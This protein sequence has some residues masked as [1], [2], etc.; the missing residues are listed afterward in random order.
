MYVSHKATRR[1]A[2]CCV[3]HVS[4]A[5][6]QA[7]A[8]AGL[9]QVSQEAAFTQ[10]FLT[11]LS[12]DTKHRLLEEE[13]QMAAADSLQRAT[14]EAK[15]ALEEYVY[16]MRSKVQGECAPFAKE[17]D[18]AALVAELNELENWLYEDG[19]DEKKSV[20]AMLKIA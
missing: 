14:D 20:R 19:E 8:P 2:A 4:A 10:V 18:S 7:E 3:P 1:P 17:A 11:D 13:G 5:R 9:V 16:A 12:K 15:N 6:R